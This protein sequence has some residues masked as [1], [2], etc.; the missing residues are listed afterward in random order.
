MPLHTGNRTIM[1]VAMSAASWS[2][3][4]ARADLL[5]GSNRTDSVL[6]FDE[7]TGELIDEFIAPGSGGLSRPGRYFRSF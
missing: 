4:A 7:G 5:V 2:L 1:L 6:R 3:T